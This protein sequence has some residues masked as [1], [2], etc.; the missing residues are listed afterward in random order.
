[1]FFSI[2]IV[3]KKFLK[4]LPDKYESLN[5][6]FSAPDLWCD[7][8]SSIEDFCFGISLFIFEKQINSIILIKDNYCEMN[9]NTI[10]PI[11][12]FK[13]ANVVTNTTEDFSN[14]ERNS[15]LDKK[16][17]IIRTLNNILIFDADYKNRIIKM[18]TN[19][20]N[21][22]TNLLNIIKYYKNNKK[23]RYY[24]T[25][26]IQ[27]IFKKNKNYLGLKCFLKRFSCPIDIYHNIYKFI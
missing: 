11:D 13:I 7:I 24:Y 8:Y 26:K 5:N 3:Y 6:Y 2:K 15:Y 27:K 23:I 9:L 1:M 16:L 17:K 18:K 4:F 21:I 20:K 25:K 22:S 19:T 14:F 10:I 12:F